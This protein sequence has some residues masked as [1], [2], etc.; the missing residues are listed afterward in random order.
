VITFAR[1]FLKLTFSIFVNCSLRLA[2]SST[3]VYFLSPG[4]VNRCRRI[5]IIVGTVL[6]FADSGDSGDYGDSGDLFRIRVLSAQIRGK[7]CFSDH[8]ITGSPDHPIAPRGTRV[9]SSPK[10]KDLANSSPGID[11]LIPGDGRPHPRRP[12]SQSPA[13]LA[14]LLVP[15]TT[16]KQTT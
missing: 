4:Y 16:C 9:P 5:R 2:L 14:T 7:D 12:L 1:A 11:L 13:M 15:A 8:P 6:S 10:T 3:L